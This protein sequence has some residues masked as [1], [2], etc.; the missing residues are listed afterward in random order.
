MNP[1]IWFSYMGNFA[2]VGWL[3]L[4]LY[5]R[6]K[7]WLYQL[8]GLIMPALMGIAYAVFMLP[9]LA[10]TVGAGYGSLA[11]VHALF[12]NPPLLLAGWIHYLAFDLAVGTYIAMQSDK[13]GL[14]R[15][16]QIPLLFLTFMF[17]PIGLMGF[18]VIKYIKQGSESLLK[19]A[20]TQGET[21]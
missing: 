12:N 9:H 10:G 6:R 15:I 2:I 14:S 19:K 8:T 11:Q 7:A 20:F 16:I 17:G 18:V 3:L 13:I 1:E 5:P 21:A 4:V